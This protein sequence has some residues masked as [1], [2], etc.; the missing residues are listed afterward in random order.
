MVSKNLSPLPDMFTEGVTI[1][2]SGVKYKLIKQK[3]NLCNVLLVGR[4]FNMQT[5]QNQWTSLSTKKQLYVPLKG[6]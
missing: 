2:Q 4:K 1:A 6:S 5:F 3:A